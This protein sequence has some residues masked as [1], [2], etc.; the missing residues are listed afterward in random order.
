MDNNDEISVIT[1]ED[2][3]CAPHL[4]FE[5]GSCMTVDILVHLANAYNEEF[6]DNKIDLNPTSIDK[7]NKKQFKRYLVNEFKTR[8]NQKCTSQRCWTQQAF[9]K[10]LSTAIQEELKT[11][12][13]REKGPAHG[14]AWLSNED[15][16]KCL[17]QYENKYDDFKFLHAVGR[18]FQE[19]NKGMF[20]QSDDFYKELI[21]K[22]N[23]RLGI[24]YNT[25][26]YGNGGE[27]W[28]ATFVNF[29][30]GE[31]SFFDSFGSSPNK[32]VQNHINQF[33]RII[34]DICSK[35]HNYNSSEHIKCNIIKK[36]INTE[37]HQQ[38]N[39]ECGVY[40]INFII[41]MLRGDS[42]EEISK[43]KISDKHINQ[44]RRVYF[45]KK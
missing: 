31:I 41:R 29:K 6:A 12:T 22:R 15:I 16:D 42:F 25:D 36:N 34:K 37:Q 32:E 8:Y 43:S 27:H 33:A 1:E 10:R 11:K 7:T 20:A 13:F 9:I 40:S 3:K 35:P 4:T 28:N 18:D 5:D 19:Y 21:K 38:E 44:C 45:S 2:K 17:F 30:E 14:T 26:K 23:L 24:I 39:S